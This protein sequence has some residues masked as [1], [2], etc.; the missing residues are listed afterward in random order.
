MSL[1]K[2]KISWRCKTVT[3]EK[4]SKRFRWTCIRSRIKLLI[5]S[6]NVWLLL[7]QL[8]ESRDK[9]LRIFPHAQ[10]IWK[11]L[12]TK[13][14]AIFH[15]FK[16]ILVL[17]LIIRYFAKPVNLEDQ[18]HQPSLNKGAKVLGTVRQLIQKNNTALALIWNTTFQSTKIQFL[19]VLWKISRSP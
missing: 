10:K 15:L 13:K 3:L 1:K 16:I 8:R 2:K 18:E 7:R 11:L 9:D 17:I 6:K 12:K 5:C 14:E 4:S 19:K